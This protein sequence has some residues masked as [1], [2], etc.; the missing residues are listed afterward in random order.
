MVN[1]RSGLWFWHK[2]SG[3]GS[4]RAVACVSRGSWESDLVQSSTIQLSGGRQDLATLYLR[5]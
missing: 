1:G 3:C 2:W 5:E 4:A